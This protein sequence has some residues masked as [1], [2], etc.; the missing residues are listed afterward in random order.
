MTLEYRPEQM[1]AADI[2]LKLFRG[3]TVKLEYEVTNLQPIDT[4]SCPYCCLDIAILDGLSAG[5]PG[6]A[7]RMQ[8]AIHEKHNRRLKDDDQK[9][10]LQG[11]GWKVV[12]FWYYDMPSLWSKKRNEK[13]E[14]TTLI[15]IMDKVGNYI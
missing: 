11:N 7:I 15:E 4:L 8:G 13:I 12:D 3:K 6:I 14:I 10:V 9:H 1:R 2:L 5:E